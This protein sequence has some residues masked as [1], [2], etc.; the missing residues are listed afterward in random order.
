MPDELGHAVGLQRLEMLA[1][2]KGKEDPFEMHVKE[3]DEETGTKEKPTLVPS[4][5]DT[6]LVGCICKCILIFFLSS[7]AQKCRID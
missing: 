2:L 5:Y 6:R 1:G 4:M 7:I 3:I